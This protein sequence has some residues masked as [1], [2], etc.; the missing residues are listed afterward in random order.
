ME[1]RS[2]GLDCNS[3]GQI[4]GRSFGLDSNSCDQIEGRSFGLDSNYG[5][6]QKRVGPLVNYMA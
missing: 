1:G 2:F 4:E 6:I 3:C 5:Q